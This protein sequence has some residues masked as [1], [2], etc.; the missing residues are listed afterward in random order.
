LRPIG[1]GSVLV[2][3]ENRA[4]L[5]A[6]IGDEVSKWLVSR[7]QFGVGVRGGLEIVQFIIRAAL[8]ASSDLTDMQ[9]DASNAFIFLRRPSFGDLLASSALRLLL[10]VA[11]MLYD[12]PSTLYAYDSSN[13]HGPDMRI[14]STRGVHKGCVFGAM[15]FAVVASRVCKQLAA[16]APNESVDCGYSDGG[17]FMELLAKLKLKLFTIIPIITG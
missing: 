16:I 4:L 9:G 3:F 11:T 14:P 10:R 8:D 5:A 12:R 15:F 2:R 1:I 6:V 13:A 17:Y 7:H